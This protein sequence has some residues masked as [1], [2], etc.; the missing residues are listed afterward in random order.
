[1][2]FYFT[3]THM[4]KLDIKFG[5]KQ[6]CGAAQEN[7]ICKLP[8]DRIARETIDNC[9]DVMH[10]NA[11]MNSNSD[12]S[13]PYKYYRESSF[14]VITQEQY[15]ILRQKY[16]THIYDYNYEAHPMQP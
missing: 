9:V 15:D 1:M 14:K 3:Y 5:H 12:E 6:D 13:I 16:Q 11:A 10:Y 2:Y 7:V 4:G 8:D